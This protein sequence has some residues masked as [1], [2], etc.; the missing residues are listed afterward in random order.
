MKKIRIPLFFRKKEFKFSRKSK[1][2]VYMKTRELIGKIII[3]E[4]VDT[5]S[6]N[7]IPKSYVINVP[8]PYKSYYSRYTDIS[9]PSSIIFVTKFPTS[10]EKI[11]RTTKKLN[12]EKGLELDGA[13]C[14]VTF[15]AKKL[16]GIRIKG[17]NR[18]PEI[19]SIQEYFFKDGYEF[20]RGENYRDKD[21]LIRVNKFFHVE[22]LEEGVYSDTDEKNT[23]Y[24]TVPNYMTWEEFRKYTFEIKNNS[25][26]T[27][28]D[29]AKGIFY[30]NGGIVEMLRIVR[31][32]AT[33]DFLK[34]IQKKYLDKMG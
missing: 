2:P 32:E 34:K 21:V 17:I 7:I 16:N 19:S 12:E 30:M 5:I 9:K 14:E 18:Y 10:F 4:K 15:G 24:V 25:T 31:P 23:Y 8:D 26:D 11:L 1:K 20:S 3:E 27:S 13:K 22:E 29:I 33:V 6:E 28:Y